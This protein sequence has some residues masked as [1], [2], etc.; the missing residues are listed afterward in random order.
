MAVIQVFSRD[1]PSL[2]LSEVARL[3]GFTR[4][5]CRRILLTLEK[6]GHVRSDGRSFML[7]PRVLTL[8]WAYLTSLN[9]SELAQPLME[10]LVERTRESCSAAT[11]DLPDIVYVAR[12]P[13]R[14]IMTIALGVGARL[15]AHATSMGRVLL[16]A[17]PEDE[18]EAYLA[19]TP[20]ERFTERTIVDLD[21]FRAAIEQVREQG[22]A[23]VDQE[24]E[25]G[26]RSVAAP[27][28]RAHSGTIAAI[29]CSAAAQRVSIDEF[30]DRIVPALLETAKLISAG[31]GAS[32]EW[33]IES[34]TRP[35]RRR[36]EP[37]P[38]LSD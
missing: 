6:L 21:E 10:D 13:T 34:F 9:L 18:F 32:G 31:A 33:Q 36:D 2:T 26:L 4:A 25:M 3:T 12:V 15:P 20:L 5:T 27:I 24:L 14:R 22:W 37:Q 16:G 1:H 29:N 8:G 38:A 30:S 7:T 35:V 23:L 11:L 28:N 19:E 17:L